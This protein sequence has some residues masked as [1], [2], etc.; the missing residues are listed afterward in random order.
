MG[1]DKINCFA[2][3]NENC[4]ALTIKDCQGCVFYK[5]KSQFRKEQA[6]ARKHVLSLEWDIRNHIIDRYY[7]GSMERFKRGNVNG[8]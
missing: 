7:N 8:C 1:I 4:S 3:K 5:S 2:Y 6:K